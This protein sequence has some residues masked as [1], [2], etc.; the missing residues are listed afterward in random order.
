MEIRTIGLKEGIA[1]QELQIYL[2][3]DQWIRTTAMDFQTF[4]SRVR[5]SSEII[6]ASFLDNF[7][8][9]HFSVFLRN[10]FILFKSFSHF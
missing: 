8:K 2:S 9:H 3:K 7:F 1:L 5:D 4:S 10:V 6:H